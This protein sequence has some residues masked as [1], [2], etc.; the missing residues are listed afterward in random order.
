MKFKKERLKRR[1]QRTHGYGRIGAHRG[2]GRRGGV[3]LT[4]GKFKH[5]WSYTMKQKALGWPDPRWMIGKHGFKRPQNIQ[6][7]E[8]VNTINVKDLDVNIEKLVEQGKATKAGKDKY[9]IDLAGLN[10]QKLLGSGAISKKIE[11]TVAKASPRA[12]EKVKKA[13]G[14]VTLAS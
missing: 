6:R 2:S 5:K 9:T 12:V 4:T 7:I 1:A 11:I 3:G 13:G 8:S 10:I 14:K